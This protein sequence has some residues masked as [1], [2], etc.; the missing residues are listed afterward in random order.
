MTS[1][2]PKLGSPPRDFPRRATCSSRELTVR[3]ILLDL[4]IPQSR[5][6]S[7]NKIQ[8][9]NKAHSRQLEDC[10]QSLR[11]KRDLFVFVSV[12]EH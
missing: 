12:R 4:P 6:Y 8:K 9:Y 1:Y 10:K 7:S 2:I 3:E 5:K 11:V